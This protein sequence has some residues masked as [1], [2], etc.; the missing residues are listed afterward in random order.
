[1]HRTLNRGAIRP[2]GANAQAQQR[3]FNALRTEYATERPHAC[4]DGRT[5]ASCY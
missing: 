3:A 2:P 1:M 4:L 5:P